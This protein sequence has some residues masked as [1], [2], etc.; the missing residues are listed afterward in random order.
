MQPDR[1]RAPLL[2]G[3]LALLLVVVAAGWWTLRDPATTLDVDALDPGRGGGSNEGAAA[4]GDVGAG[5]AAAT[6]SLLERVEQALEDGDDTALGGLAAGSSRSRAV[7][8]R[9]ADNVA[10]IGLEDVRLRY[11][12]A[13]LDAP[14]RWTAEVE[15]SYRDPFAG[16]RRV[17]V[18]AAVSFA[19]VGGQSD[20]GA[21]Q[22]ALVGA[23]AAGA[24][25]PLWMSA[26]LAVRT[27][28]RVSARVD[29]ASTLGVERVLA[30]G[31]TAV[32]EVTRTLPAWDGPLVIEVPD[33]T[34]EVA[35]VLGEPEGAYDAV[36]AVT[37][38]IDGSASPGAPVHVVVNPVVL[39]TLGNR[40]EQVVMTHEAVHVATDASTSPELPLWLMEGYADWAA[41]RVTDLPDDV[42]AGAILERVREQGP[43]GRLPGELEFDPA[44]EQFGVSYEAAWLAVR[45]M[46]ERYGPA[47]TIAFYEQVDGGAPVAQ[48]FSTLGTTE[49]Q[50]TRAWQRYLQRLAGVPVGRGLVSS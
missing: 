43:P 9:W 26:D 30:L 5:R 45:L 12:A 40:G 3:V 2:V 4:T 34:V 50:F 29:E 47:A 11:V 39:G 20:A 8:D 27:V 33:D 10:A 1:T 7:L 13:T 16:A 41:L 23:G 28:D 25:T 17:R 22:V 36:A 35:H 32:R 18:A 6:T 14:S 49:R 24:R 46:A 48:A 38:T 21:P 15:V 37:T 31:R 42:A 19:D 44:G